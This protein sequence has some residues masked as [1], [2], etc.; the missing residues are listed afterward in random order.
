VASR[1]N[2]TLKDF[3]IVPFFCLLVVDDVDDDDDDDDVCLCLCLLPLPLSLSLP[4][5]PLFQRY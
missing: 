4:L 2:P 5:P 1:K 3:S